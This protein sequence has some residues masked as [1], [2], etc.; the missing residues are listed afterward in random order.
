ML[1]DSDSWSALHCVDEIEELCGL[2]S[3]HLIRDMICW[4]V[5]KCGLVLARQML[6]FFVVLSVGGCF[7]QSAK[8]EVK[9]FS[10]L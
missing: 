1:V 9:L 8:L 3:Q 7:L 10:V 4:R 5:P 6:V 2:D